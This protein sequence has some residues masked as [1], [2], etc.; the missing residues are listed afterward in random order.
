[1]NEALPEIVDVVTEFPYWMGS[2]LHYLPWLRYKRTLQGWKWLAVAGR[3]ILHVN[4]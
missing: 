4:W 2:E 3:S 1:M